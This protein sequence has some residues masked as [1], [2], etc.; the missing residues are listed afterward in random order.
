MARYTRKRYSGSGGGGCGSKQCTAGEELGKELLEKGSKGSK[1]SKDANAANTVPN[2]KS[3]SKVGTKKASAASAASTASNITK[4]I[5]KI[6]A[7]IEK[8]Q[9]ELDSA[10]SEGREDLQK[11][12]TARSEN[13][14]QMYHKRVAN[15]FVRIKEK[16]AYI[17]KYK[18]MIQ[19][20]SP[21]SPQRG[22]SKKRSSCFGGLCGPGH[23][24]EPSRVVPNP[25]APMTGVKTV[26]AANR[27]REERKQKRAEKKE[28]WIKSKMRGSKYP[29]LNNNA[30]R[31]LFETNWTRKVISGTTNKNSNN[32][33]SNM[34]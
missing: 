7:T 3:K 17:K 31:S 25:V 1:G 20:L 27:R 32:E 5:N 13:D 12:K 16:K 29:G 8:L 9:K 15:M 24:E 11:A 28:E 10:A 14:Y 21:K 34:Y 18:D 19:L 26:T 23:V 30:R 4:H 33:F 22:G 2:W 6:Q